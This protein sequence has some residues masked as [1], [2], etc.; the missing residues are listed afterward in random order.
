[1]KVALHYYQA[2]L[3]LAVLVNQQDS[4]MCLSRCSGRQLKLFWS[5]YVSHGKK[6]KTH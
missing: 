3:S 1:M 6:I 5:N 2:Y 4:Q